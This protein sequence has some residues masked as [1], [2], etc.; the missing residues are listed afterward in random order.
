MLQNAAEELLSYSTIPTKVTWTTQRLGYICCEEEQFS[1]PVPSFLGSYL[2]GFLYHRRMRISCRFSPLRMWLEEATPRGAS[3]SSKRGHAEFHSG[4]ETSLALFQR[5]WWSSCI[6]GWPPSS[7]R[8][9]TMKDIYSLSISRSLFSR[10]TN[11][12]QCLHISFTP[13]WHICYQ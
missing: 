2:F 12:A 4:F 13:K 1:F 6:G 7:R 5:C 3:T 10:I 11:I 8:T 9:L